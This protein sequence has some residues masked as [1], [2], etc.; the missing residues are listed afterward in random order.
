MQRNQERMFGEAADTGLLD[1]ARAFAFEYLQSVP[2]RRA[3]P[4]RH[5]L[6]ALSGFQEP[7]PESPTSGEAVVTRLSQLGGPATAVHTGGRYFGFVNG[8]II[9]AALAAKWVA[10]A[11]DQNAALY[12][13]SP[14]ASQLEAVCERWLRELFELPDTTGVGFVSGTSTGTLCGLAAGRNALLR[15]LG[16]DV[17]KDGLFGAPTLRVVLGAQAHATVGKAL[18]ILGLG[19]ERIEVVPSDNEGRMVLNGLMLDARTLV[20][21]QAGNVNTGAFD[22]FSALNRIAREVGA[23]V[24]VDGAFG[25]WAHASRR[26]RHLTR[27]VQG[28]DSWSVDAHKTLNAPYDCGLV[29]C[30][31]KDDLVEAMQTSA[32]YIVSTGDRDGMHYTLDMSRRARSIELWATM[33]SLGRAGIEELVDDLCANAHRLA[34]GLRRTGFRI[35]NEV[36]FNQVLI[37]GD[38]PEETRGTLAELQD[39]GECWCG[40]ATWKNEPAIRASVCSWRT[41]P[42]DIDVA[43]AAFERARAAHRALKAA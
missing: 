42:A 17:N 16:W 11:W 41:T 12:L 18:G 27:D 9:P 8:G 39:G 6:D 1:L 38:T 14:V 40:G 2:S 24:H 26:Y 21:A 32:S 33:K 20:V 31:V 5:A 7:M 37:S 25:L 22:D 4:T 36:V 28:A 3:F 10:D 34:E 23:W 29:L 30:R 15:R 35:L 13:T 43:I 19:R